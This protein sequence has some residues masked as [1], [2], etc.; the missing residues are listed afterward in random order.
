MAKKHS[1]DES[2]NWRVRRDPS[3]QSDQVQ[4]VQ[5]LGA[6]YYNHNNNYENYEN[7]TNHG[8]YDS[9]NKMHYNNT[10]TNS[11][12]NGYHQN[13]HSNSYHM[14]SGS[15]DSYE[16]H[17]SCYQQ[18]HK[19]RYTNYHT[20]ES[21]GN[22]SSSKQYYKNG[23]TFYT[24][25]EDV[26]PPP[27]SQV[28]LRTGKNQNSVVDK[29]ESWRRSAS[30][31]RS[32]EI[33]K[34]PEA[35]CHPED[36]TGSKR[37]QLFI[38]YESPSEIEK[39][40]KDGVYYQGIMRLTKNRDDAYVTVEELADD[41]YI[42]GAKNRNRSLQGDLVAVRLLDNVEEAWNTK[43]ERDAK[44]K[45]ER[46]LQRLKER[47]ETEILSEDSSSKEESG[48]G[49]ED[50]A[51]NEDEEQE[52][53]KPRYSGEVVG[54]ILRPPDATYPGYI[55]IYKRSSSHT[56]DST[57]TD[58]NT[59]PSKLSYAWFRPTDKRVPFLMLR[60]DDI[61]KDL[62]DN[63]EY[64]ASHLFSASIRRW[65]ITDSSPLGKIIKELGPVGDLLVE[66]EA[67]IAD[68]NV[69]ATNFSAAALKFLPELP[70]S[71]H[72]RELKLRKD[73]RLKCVFSIDPSTAKDLDDAL[74][75]EKLEDGL[76]EVG[77]HIADVS[78]FLKKGSALDNEA[79]SRGTSTYLVDSVIP[80]LPPT[81][82]EELCSLN[83]GVDRLAFS[84]IWTMD[85]NGV[86]IDTWF[87]KTIIRSCAKLAYEDA[88]S[89]IDGGEIPS[90]IDI[91]GD[92]SHSRIAN[93]ILLLN[94]IAVNKRKKR[95][96]DGSLSLN[97][98]KLNFELDEYG[99][100]IS[101]HT[102]EQKA[103]NQLIE[104]FMLSANISVARKITSAY[105]DEALLR[106]HEEPLERRLQK[107]LRLTDKL[108]LD[109]D[110]YSAGALQESFNKITNPNVK[111][112]LL[113]LAIRCMQRAKYFCAGVADISKYG[114]YALNES[115]Y[116]HFTSPI[117]RY[118]DVIVHRMLESALKE[119]D[120]RYEKKAVQNIAFH[121]NSKKEGARGAQDGSVNVYLAKY[122]F[123]LE[124]SSGCPIYAEGVVIAV[125]N[126]VFEVYIPKF[127]LERKFHLEALPT[128]RY[129]FDKTTQT[130]DIFWKQGVPVT[131]H[132]EEQI[133]ARER[134]RKD[135]YSDEEIE[136]KSEEDEGDFVDD[137]DRLDL[138]ESKVLNSDS[139]L[140]PPVVLDAS[141]GLQRLKMFSSINIRI[142]VNMTHS[143]P[144]VNIY[145]VNPFSGEQIERYPFSGEQ[146]ERYV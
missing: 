46:K 22:H 85:A 78:Y 3:L 125:E 6:T 36:R 142:Q 4:P 60:N 17:H 144:I 94:S 140:V 27:K 21:Y 98:V 16:N 75:I 11:Y 2:D 133:Y 33:F 109:F 19:N 15:I 106:R 38:P 120:C 20:S 73:L 114:H 92:H 96:T 97:S 37:K 14:Q 138:D 61:P 81:L 86:P 47:G 100:P 51:E 48:E 50:N 136:D 25:M 99:E 129:H 130:L 39:G 110:G 28:K 90:S 145:P 71:I 117:R 132:N 67:L 80:M 111:N 35:Y 83:P 1:A 103:A 123:N 104:E 29:A 40:I 69:I 30:E 55:S 65:Q 57:T 26:K 105:P 32:K 84:V 5:H 82:C 9:Y 113:V 45:K 76:F 72:E 41:I 63:E 18:E 64:Y 53:F 58:T 70:W 77:V 139:D 122:L 101:V 131:M 119:K 124:M 121:C 10:Y 12:Y 49:K 108:G 59:K 74:H 146:V 42:G 141:T 68:N 31:S 8:H 102:F 24:S 112:V 13:Y 91:D 116:T 43:K 107:F 134:V 79:K 88:Q 87:G 137:F 127:G 44:R 126:E 34:P 118:A 56:N 66:R 135:D 52:S 7:S 115:L 89:V 95:Y 143:P 62:I 93:D 128:E 23:T 54:I